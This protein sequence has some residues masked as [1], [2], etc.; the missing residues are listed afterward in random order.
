MAITRVL[1]EQAVLE[2][3]EEAGQQGV[4]VS[5]QPVS[6]LHETERRMDPRQHR[7]ELSLQRL[8]GQPKIQYQILQ[9][10]KFQLQSQQR[11]LGLVPPILHRMRQSLPKTNRRS[12]SNLLLMT[13]KQIMD[14]HQPQNYAP[15]Q[16]F[17]DS[18]GLR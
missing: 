5:I 15:S 10:Q 11:I 1:G 7:Q 12:R 4:L 13:R 16:V 17:P 6:V 18:H 14:P 8:H 3:E 2:D 9:L